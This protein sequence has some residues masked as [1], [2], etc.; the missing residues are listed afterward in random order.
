[1]KERR[2]ASRSEGCRKN[3]VSPKWFGR[4]ISAR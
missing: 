1:L 4:I 2:I 3:M